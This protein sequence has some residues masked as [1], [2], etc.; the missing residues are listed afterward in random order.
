[1]FYKIQN[2]AQQNQNFERKMFDIMNK[3][4]GMV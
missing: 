4:Q 2:S 1:M 3:M